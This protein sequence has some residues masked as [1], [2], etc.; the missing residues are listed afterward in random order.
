MTIME[1]LT[2]CHY[3]L[4]SKLS[5]R[6]VAVAQ[7]SNK[8]TKPQTKSNKYLCCIAGLNN[9]QGGHFI[10]CHV[11]VL[12]QLFLFLSLSLSLFYLFWCEKTCMM[13]ELFCFF[14][15]LFYLGHGGIARSWKLF[16]L[17]NKMF[18]SLVGAEYFIY[19]RIAIFL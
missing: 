16:K 17:I 4:H 3:L 9:A 5:W 19:F 2:F 6:A 11:L 12:F 1:D 13:I 15:I 7:A 18:S 14:Y 10:N 8:Q